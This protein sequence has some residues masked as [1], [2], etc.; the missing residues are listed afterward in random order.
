LYRPDCFHTD[1]GHR[2][3]ARREEVGMKQSKERPI[4]AEAFGKAQ[5][6]RPRVNAKERRF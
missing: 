6:A 5:L 3:D 4:S 1:F 2:L